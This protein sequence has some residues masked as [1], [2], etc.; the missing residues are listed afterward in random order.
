MLIC[1]VFGGIVIVIEIVVFVGVITVFEL[2]FLSALFPLVSFYM[3]GE[4]QFLSMSL[5]LLETGF[6]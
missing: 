3:I 1:V 6:L 2:I 4:L 5:L